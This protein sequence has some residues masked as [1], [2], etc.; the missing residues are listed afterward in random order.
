M[1]GERILL[2]EDH[3]DLSLWLG[4][5]LRAR[6]IEVEFAL[7][8]AQADRMAREGGWDLIVLDLSLP[9]M[10]GLQVLARLRER[11]DAVPV[12]VLTARGEVA[13]RVRGL[14]LGADDYL[15]KP[16][17]PS[18]F[19]AR[20]AALLR[21][22]KGYKPKRTIVGDLTYDHEQHAF[23]RGSGAS[24]A[25]LALT[26]REAALLL[27]LFEREGRAVSKEF[28]HETL[29]P[30]GDANLDAVEVNVYRLRKKVEPCG[31]Q[32]VTV[33]GLGYML[34]RK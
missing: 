1:S 6:G 14:N 2:V 10:D 7:D 24:Q 17:E 4:K 30:D 23:Y 22:P 9:Q 31:V 8:G 19:E 27:A 11:G 18:E 20:V 5:T 25:P 29:F 33:R 28:L 32:I 16:F 15:A 12:L 21:R 26:K 3:A 13:D 34:E